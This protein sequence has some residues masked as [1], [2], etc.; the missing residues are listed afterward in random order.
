MAKILGLDLGTNSIGWAVVDATFNKEGKVDSYNFIDDAG[1]RI[2]PEGVEPKTIGQGDKEQSKNSTRREHRQMRRQYYRKRLRKI[3][4][5]EVLI[6]QGMCPIEMDELKKWKNWDRTKKTEGKKF[7][8]TEEFTFWINLNPYDL[9]AK[10]L[11][12]PITMFEL[13]R[14]FY[15]FIQRR[16]FLSSRK[17][18]DES[19]IFTKGKPDENILPINQTKAEIGNSTLGNHLNTIRYKDN[20]PFA[21]KT[22]EEG[23]E[24][25]PRGRYTTREMYIDEFEKIWKKQSEYLDIDERVV[26]AQKVREL[27]GSLDGIRNSL[28]IM[29]L[30][31]KYGEE[32]ITIEAVGAKGITKITSYSKVSLKE[33]LAGNIEHEIDA[34]GNDKL[35]FKS[36]ESVLFWQ[37][38]LRSQKSLLSNCRFENELPVIMGNGEIRIKNNK[39]VTRS[40]KPCPISHPEFE[41]FRAF[42][43]VNNIRFGKNLPLSNE[44]KSVVLDII[45]KK[46]KNFDFGLIPKTLKL[47]YE[48]FNY[49]DKFKVAG[50]PT[51][52]QLKPLFPI[53]VWAEHFEEIWHCFYFYEDNN[54]LFEKMQRDFGFRKDIETIKKVRLKEGYGNVSLKA[55]RNIMPFLEKGFQY[56]RAVLLGGIKNAFGERWEYFAD[57]HHEIERAVIRIMSEENKDGEAI[58]KIKDSSFALKFKVFSFN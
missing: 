51:L 22:N 38:P 45:N 56:D 36:N 39:P 5:L 1:V 40:K 30:N 50:N 2:F 29:A 23:F 58:E 17:G 34:D 53:K 16:G 47:T 41:L 32:N 3:K 4:L 55:I 28:K 48:K 21:R 19:S 57:F 33:F 6:K 18:N 25:R 35:Q 15:H 8:D 27:K 54:K 24:I 14:I 10:A 31:K 9:R 43:F 20:E 26:D 12:E 46:D 7:P 37:R 42:Q 44:Q 52:K 11:I 49:D 13:G